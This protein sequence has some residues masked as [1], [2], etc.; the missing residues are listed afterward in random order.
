MERPAGDMLT[1]SQSTG[2]LTHATSLLAVG[3]SGLGEARNKPN[4]EDQAM[5]GPIPRGRFRIDRPHV[6][7]GS[8]MVRLR[9]IDEQGRVQRYF[10][11][12]GD[13]SKGCIIVPPDALASIVALI[14]GGQRELLVTS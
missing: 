6:F 11:K 12:A 1:Y 13:V 8:W 9:P 14:H 3:F 4:L 2:E 5:L 10:L 7:R